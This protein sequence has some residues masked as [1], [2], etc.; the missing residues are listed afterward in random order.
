MSLKSKADLQLTRNRHTD[1]ETEIQ[2][3]TRDILDKET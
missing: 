3:L 2:K 1:L